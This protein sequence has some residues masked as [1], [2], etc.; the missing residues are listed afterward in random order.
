MAKKVQT[1]YS[2]D[3]NPLWWMEIKLWFGW[4]D[5]PKTIL[6][7]GGQIFS[8]LLVFW[9]GGKMESFLD[10][11]FVTVAGWIFGIL[12]IP[13]IM[14]ITYI[15]ASNKLYDEQKIKQNEQ[16]V[17]NENIQNEM[18]AKLKVRDQEI[19]KLEKVI[20][21]LKEKANPD[22]RVFY[23]LQ[24]HK[25]YAVK[26][27]SPKMIVDYLSSRLLKILRTIGTKDERITYYIDGV[28]YFAP[29]KE[30]AFEYG[31]VMTGVRENAI[32]GFF[33][34]AGMKMTADPESERLPEIFI[35]SISQGG[36]GRSKTALMN[37]DTT[38]KDV[39]LPITRI[40]VRELKK[41]LFELESKE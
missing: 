29:Q 8:I 31:V 18:D 16:I 13:L 5:L 41:G 6:K 35:I 17:K 11:A 14:F 21:T 1:N 40:L 19:N 26:N 34:V 27:G 12:I 38:V 3:F 4:T 9:L 30:S 23:Q 22:L 15:R 36:Q 33:E 20:G 2:K 25:E 39:M 28:S 32:H 7:T 24:Y 37:F 10:S